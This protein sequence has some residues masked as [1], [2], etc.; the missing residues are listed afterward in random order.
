MHG[1]RAD[2]TRGKSKGAF[3]G[4]RSGQIRS[5]SFNDPWPLLEGPGGRWCWHENDSGFRT[6]RGQVISGNDVRGSGG[7]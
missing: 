7:R 4:P 3:T 6:L 1:T 2:G 5:A